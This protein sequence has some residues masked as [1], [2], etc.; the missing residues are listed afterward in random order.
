MNKQTPSVRDLMCVFA[1]QYQNLPL[2]TPDSYKI[3]RKQAADGQATLDFLFFTQYFYFSLFYS[4]ICHKSVYFLQL[5]SF[6]FRGG[7]MQTVA[8]KHLKE[9]SGLNWQVCF[10][11]FLRAAGKVRRVIID[12]QHNTALSS[13]TC[14]W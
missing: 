7:D 8:N 9:G 4:C 1:L 13:C 12:I 2:P 6:R 10:F 5:I 14:R 11:A 3:C